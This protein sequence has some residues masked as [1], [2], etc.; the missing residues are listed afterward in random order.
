MI[1]GIGRVQDQVPI[2]APFEHLFHQPSAGTLCLGTRRCE[3]Q[4][5]GGELASV[6]EPHRASENAPDAVNSDDALTGAMTVEEI[7]ARPVAFPTVAGHGAGPRSAL[8]RVTRERCIDG[9]SFQFRCCQG[10]SLPP[11]L[12]ARAPR[13]GILPL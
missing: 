4:A 13:P 9:I 10:S 3:Y 12:C 7:L 11:G 2:A 6:R 5:D 1:G 8:C